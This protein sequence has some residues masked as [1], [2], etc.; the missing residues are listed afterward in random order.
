MIIN[1]VPLFNVSL[2]EKMTDSVD[3]KNVLIKINFIA[4]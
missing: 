4:I 2:S 3:T 1:D